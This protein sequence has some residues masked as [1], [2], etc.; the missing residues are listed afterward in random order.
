MYNCIFSAHC[1]EA[2]CDKS[3]PIL[4]ET[5]YLLERN[6]IDMNNS[7]FNTSKNELSIANTMLSDL[8]G[9]IGYYKCSNSVKF[10]DTLTYTAICRNWK[11]S[12]LHCTVYNLKFAKYLENI[13]DSWAGTNNESLEYMKIWSESAKVL[14]ISG[15]DFVNF[16]DFESQTLLNLIQS[17][18][19]NNTTTILVGGLEGVVTKSY[20]TNAFAGILK[21][22]LTS[23]TYKPS[24]GGAS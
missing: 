5:S 18:I 19:N 17:R 20:N 7:V 16:G 24:R 10:A 21:Q 13:K 9:K 22:R 6:G 23:Y 1:T 2:F 15:F 11:G 12:K 8:S 4:V 14:I 3:C